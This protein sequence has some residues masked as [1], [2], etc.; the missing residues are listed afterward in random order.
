MWRIAAFKFA[1]P[2]QL[3]VWAGEW[4][5][6]PVRFRSEHAPPGLV[7]AIDSWTEW[8]APLQTQGVDGFA[9]SACLFFL[10]VA[11]LSCARLV[12]ERLRLARW[13]TA[14]ERIRVERDPDDTAPG[15][16]FWRGLVFTALAFFVIGAPVLAGA[17][18]DRED[19]YAQLVADA[20]ALRTA[21][22]RM[23]PAAPGMGGRVRVSADADGI[24]IRNATI[25]DL[26]GIAYGVN[27]FFVRGDHFIEEGEEDWLTGARYDLRIA[28]RIRDPQRFDT[29]ALRAPVTKWLAERHGLEIYVNS[30]CQ[31][32]CGR[33]GVAM[34]DVPL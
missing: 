23:K 5:G 21:D 29:Y 2:Y 11:T 25:R 17:V 8:L 4:L 18:R 13:Q 1:L 22:I 27:R 32:P 12:A 34:P 7:S 14:R 24:T 19:R 6:F 9:L 3:A 26:A 15:L 20:R 31:P 10:L 16:G 33:Y 30:E 28:G